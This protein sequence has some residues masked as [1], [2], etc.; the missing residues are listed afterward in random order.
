MPLGVDRTWVKYIEKG[1][2]PDTKRFFSVMR[3]NHC[4]DAPCVEICPTTALY[5]RKD[6]VVDFDTDNCIGCKSCMQA[7]PY[8]ALYI[9]PQEHT[10]QK[11]NYC[12]HRV[13]VGM[14]PACVVVCPEQ[15]IVAGDLDDP[16]SQIAKMVA[17][18]KLSQ[19]ATEQGT[20]PKL[21]YKGVESANIDPLAATNPQDG[22]IWRDPAASWLAVDLTPPTVTS[23]SAAVV[24]SAPRN[25][26]VHEGDAPPRIVY[27]K[28][29]PMPWGWRVSS[30]FLTKGISAGLTI[31]L[32]LALLLGADLTTGWARWGSP[33]VAGLFLALTGGLLVWDLKRPDR[34]YYLLTRGNPSSWLVKGAWILSAYGAVLGIWFLSGVAEADDVVKV[35]IWVGAPL[36][37]GVAGYTAFLFAQAEGRDLW[38]SP[39]LLWHMVAGAFAA[40]GGFGL[41]VALVV[42]V[43][44]TTERAFAWA[45]VGGAAVLGL[46]AFAEIT[47]KHP[48]RNIA[49]AVHHM[50]RGAYAREWWLG[51]QLLGVVIPIALGALFLGGGELWLA[52]VGGLAACAGIWFSDDAYVKAG[53]SVPLA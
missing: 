40:G 2:W 51:G 22:G 18:E 15:A 50:T 9:D 17:T 14:Q 20:K 53:Q 1:S 41:L 23:E 48:T 45:M 21:W 29:S 44:A 32:A 5:N 7:C 8:D 30:Y 12:A 47:T 42:D 13:D 46:F 52:A 3:C 10:A 27:G 31:A 6:G 36:G 33:L 39:M 35:L 26:I 37:V 24:P 43:G 38:Q 11:C 49:E 25:R 16:N 34:F 28:D 4:E 19:R